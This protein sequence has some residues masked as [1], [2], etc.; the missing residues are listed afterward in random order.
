MYNLSIEWSETVISSNVS[1]IL[2]SSSLFRCYCKI[3]VTH[4]V[5]LTAFKE[6]INQMSKF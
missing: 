4:S 6:H 5:T 2:S 1:P 3:I